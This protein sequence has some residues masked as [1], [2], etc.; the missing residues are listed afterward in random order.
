MNKNSSIG[1]FKFLKDLKNLRSKKILDLKEFKEKEGEV[2]WLS[3][4]PKETETRVIIHYLEDSASHSSNNTLIEL[5]KPK[6]PSYPQPPD[7]VKSWIKTDLNNYNEDIE[8]ADS[9]PIPE[10]ERN[11][12]EGSKQDDETE[13][14]N[15]GEMEATNSDETEEPQR[16]ILKD[17]KDI[18]KMFLEYKDKWRNWADERKRLE[19]VIK[20]Y[21]TL[22]K[23]HQK[24]T[25]QAENFEL[26]LG[27]VYK[28]DKRHF[29]RDQDVFPPRFSWFF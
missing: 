1:L 14:T 20:I 13:V 28:Q 16:K 22:Y 4:I 9:I 21:N 5:K 27:V 24:G 15:S 7:A 18:E 12:Q 29:F 8:C 17:H 11:H 23:I 6:I 3:E 19:P 2:I 10:K 25:I 26:V